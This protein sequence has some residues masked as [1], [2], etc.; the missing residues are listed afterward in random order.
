[1][2]VSFTLVIHFP[3]LFERIGIP[4]Y[5]VRTIF[6]FMAVKWFGKLLKT[7]YDVGRL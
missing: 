4:I 3:F 1:M 2:A 6:Y 5:E 7:G